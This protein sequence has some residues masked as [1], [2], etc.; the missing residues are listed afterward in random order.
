MHAFIGQHIHELFF[1]GFVYSVYCW[2]DENLA[3]VY[4]FPINLI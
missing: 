4:K 2:M 1:W 3:T